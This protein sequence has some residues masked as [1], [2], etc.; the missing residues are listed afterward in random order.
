M[1]F[2]PTGANYVDLFSRLNLTYFFKNS[3]II[4]SGT[5]VLSVILGAVAAYSFARY[6]FPMR[7]FLLFMVLFSRM[8]P[9]V[10][11]VVPLF[12]VMRRLGFT[13]TYGGIILLYTAFQTPFVIWMMRGFFLSIPRELEEAAVIEGCSRLTAFLRSL[14][15]QS[16]VLAA[17][18][19]LLLLF[20]GMNFSRLNSPVPKIKLY[21]SPVPELIGEMGYTGSNRAAGT[22]AVLPF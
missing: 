15:S 8:L 10:A 9:P 2:K 11:G 1:F 19:I 14:S 21:Q 22:L 3:I 12:L 4:A 5:A 7:K 17:T 18:S 6:N 16:T 20:L 13:D